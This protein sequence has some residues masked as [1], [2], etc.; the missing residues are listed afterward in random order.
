MPGRGRAD[1]TGCMTKRIIAFAL[2]Q[3][4]A[5]GWVLHFLYLH[6]KPVGHSGH[7]ATQTAS[8]LTHY[9]LTWPCPR[10][11]PSWSSRSSP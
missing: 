9:L 10:R 1:F 8:P 5:V 7:H 11:S 4:L 3:A 2:T 6:P